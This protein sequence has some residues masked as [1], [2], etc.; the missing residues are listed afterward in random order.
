MY[1]FITVI[2][3]STCSKA[4]LKRKVFLDPE[5]VMYSEDITHHNL[6]KKQ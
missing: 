5:D 6:V 2:L 3:K 1:D 4:A